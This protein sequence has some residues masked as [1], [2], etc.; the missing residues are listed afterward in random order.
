[1]FTIM[2]YTSPLTNP[3]FKHTFSDL[4]SNICNIDISLMDIFN[5]LDNL[6][7]NLFPGPDNKFPKFLYN[8]RFI[9]SYPIHYLF[10]QSLSSGIFQ[11]TRN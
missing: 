11:I 5:E 2:E 6:N 4:I 7:I 9:L 8:Y 10:K 3:K 1:M